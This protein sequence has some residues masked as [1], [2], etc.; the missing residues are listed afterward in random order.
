V[1]RCCH[2]EVVFNFFAKVCTFSAEVLHR[3]VVL[4]NYW[5]WVLSSSKFYAKFLLIDLG[6][7]ENT[8]LLKRW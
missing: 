5:G 3:W 1:L 4:E 6:G 8:S 2:V 7:Q